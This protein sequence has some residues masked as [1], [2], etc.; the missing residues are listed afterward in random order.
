MRTTYRTT[1]SDLSTLCVVDGSNLR[2]AMRDAGY[3]GIDIDAFMSFVDG[4]GPSKTFWFQGAYPQTEPFFNV[5]RSRGV[6]VHA[7]APKCLPNGQLKCDLDSALTVVA[8]REAPSYDTV[9]LVTGDGDM[10]Y[11]VEELARQ[12]KRVVIV[13]YEPMMDPALVQWCGPGDFVNLESLLASCG[14]PAVAA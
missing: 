2:F 12:D 14:N 9:V 1:S 10:A 6:V 8:M 3:K 7:P 13:G 4:W 11:L 5:L